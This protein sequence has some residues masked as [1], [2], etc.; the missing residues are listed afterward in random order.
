[1]IIMCKLNIVATPKF[2]LTVISFNLYCEVGFANSHTFSM[3]FLST[4]QPP[5][6]VFNINLCVVISVNQFFSSVHCTAM[7]FTNI[8]PYMQVGRLPFWHE[9]G[10]PVL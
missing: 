4:Y 7:T 10:I 1:M 8:K 9:T 3:D 2:K 5:F 6:R